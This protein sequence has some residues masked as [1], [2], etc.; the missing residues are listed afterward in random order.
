MDYYY[1]LAYLY[2]N[3]PEPCNTD[4]GGIDACSGINNGDIDFLTWFHFCEGPAYICEEYD[5][6][7]TETNDIVEF[8]NVGI[9]PYVTNWEIE[10]YLYLEDSLFGM[11]LPFELNCITSPITI[12]DISFENS[13]V[14]EL[15]GIDTVGYIDKNKCLI[16]IPHYTP[17]CV[18]VPGPGDG[19]IA[20][21]EIT[22][23][24]SVD[25]QF[26]A[27]ST[28]VFEPSHILIFSRKHSNGYIYPFIPKIDF[29][30]SPNLLSF[31]YGPNQPLAGQPV[32]NVNLDVY[33][34]G[35]QYFQTMGPTDAS[36]TINVPFV[37]LETDEIYAYKV[38]GAGRT[39]K[40]LHP[41]IPEH[42]I[43]QSIPGDCSSPPWRAFYFN[44]LDNQYYS[45]NELTKFLYEP[46]NNIIQLN[47]EIAKLQLVVGFDHSIALEDYPTV[48]D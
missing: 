12:N 1:L 14:S 41:N 13:F 37:L 43:P 20:T 11:S 48:I 46:G 9:P 31:V 3:G 7:P 17:S 33:R 5:C 10:V 26:I 24:P 44:Y 19:L 15:D 34:D 23:N 4:A 8:R 32:E 25:S 22:I 38:I 21:L 2:E 6:S 36:G 29:G 42:I 35:Q 47:H 45:G 39:E 27:I 30:Y 18:E 16:A 28:T 40:E